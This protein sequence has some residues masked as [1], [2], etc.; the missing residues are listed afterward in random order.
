MCGIAFWS[1]VQVEV[2]LKYSLSRYSYLCLTLLIFVGSEE[3]I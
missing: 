2:D 3:A 1:G